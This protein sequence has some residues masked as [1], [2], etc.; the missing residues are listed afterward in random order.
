[1]CALSVAATFSASNLY[2]HM[3]AFPGHDWRLYL[4]PL[5]S[6]PTAIYFLVRAFRS[7][8]EINYVRSYSFLGPPLWSARCRS[9]TSWDSEGSLGCCQGGLRSAIVWLWRSR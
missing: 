9:F 6:I 7:P 1:M 2:K 5:L 3:S 8:R 4:L